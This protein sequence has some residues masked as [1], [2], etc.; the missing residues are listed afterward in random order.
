[1]EHGP[2]KLNFVQPRS[3]SLR[4]NGHP[5]IYAS[6]RNTGPPQLVQRHVTSANASPASSSPTTAF[7]RCGPQ[8]GAA[9][10]AFDEIPRTQSR[11]HVLRNAFN[12]PRFTPPPTPT[13]ASPFCSASPPSHVLSTHRDEKSCCLSFILFST[14]SLLPFTVCCA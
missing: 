6:R 8:F 4:V 14:T 5:E 12:Y 9:V 2:P 11:Q 7:M 3:E 10:P 1:M 13:K